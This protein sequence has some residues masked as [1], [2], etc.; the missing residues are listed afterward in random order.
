MFICLVYTQ[1]TQNLGPNLE[2][3]DI[4]RTVRIACQPS[5]EK[6]RLS[7]KFHLIEGNNEEEC[8]TVLQEYNKPKQN[9]GSVSTFTGLT[10]VQSSNQSSVLWGE[11]HPE[12]LPSLILPIGRSAEAETGVKNVLTLEQENYKLCEMSGCGD[13]CDGCLIRFYHNSI[14]EDEFFEQSHVSEHFKI[15][16]IC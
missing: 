1:N 11:P 15:I 8:K 13:L 12:Q 2:T 14:D 10:R 7:E 3:P 6:G 9:N 4:P 5:S 16:K